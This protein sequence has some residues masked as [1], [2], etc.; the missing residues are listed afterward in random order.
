VSETLTRALRRI[1]SFTWQGGGVDAWLH[2]ILRNVVLEAHRAEHRVVSR[3]A[4]DEV[5]ADG[6]PEEAVLRREQAV[7]VRTALATLPATDQQVLDLR[8]VSCLSAD[9]VGAVLRK[10]P[11]AVRMAQSRALG[12]LR[13][14]LEDVSLDG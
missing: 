12:R 3:D 8:F 6:G 7:L 4:G 13:R 5:A 2:G 10:G 11:G 14:A 1:G 9:E